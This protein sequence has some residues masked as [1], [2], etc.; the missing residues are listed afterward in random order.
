ML[1]KLKITLVEKLRQEDW[2]F[3]PKILSHFFS[4]NNIASIFL[5]VPGSA[6]G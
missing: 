1:S 5:K 4:C 3:A 2:K 6:K